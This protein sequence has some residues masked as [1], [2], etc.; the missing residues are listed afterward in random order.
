MTDRTA[1][2]GHISQEPLALI[3]DD[4]EAIRSLVGEVLQDLGMGTLVAS[5]GA[6]AVQIALEHRTLLCCAILDVRMPV[7]DGLGAARAIRKIA[8]TLA[9]IMM[10][11]SFPSGYRQQIESL[12]IAHVLDKPFRLNELRGIVRGISVAAAP[13]GGHYV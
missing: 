4:D 10:S 6:A 5:D 3:A 8:P 1:P 12:G 11:S 9:I 7:L 2:T 13:P